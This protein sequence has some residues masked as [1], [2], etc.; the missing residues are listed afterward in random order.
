MTKVITDKYKIKELL[1]LGV[2]EIIVKKDLEKKLLSGK[3]LRIKH[4]VDPTSADLHLG[5]AVVY[6]KL[7]ELQ[8]LGHKIIFLIGGFTGRFGDPTDKEKARNLRTKEETLKLAKNY[9]KQLAKIL[10]IDK[11]EIRDNSEWYDKWSFE[12]GLKLISRFTVARMLERDM[13]VKRQEQGKE[14]YYHEPIYPM[15]QGWDSVELRSDLTVIG[16]DQKFNE[17]QARPLQQEQGQAP[18]D[19]ITVPLLIGTD[20]K[21][22]MSQSLGN[23]IGLDESANEQFGKIMSIPDKLLLHYFELVARYK[24]KDLERVKK[25]L[26]E[27]RNPK[28]LKIELAKKI[29]AIYHNLQLAD[30]AAQEFT[31]VFSNKQKPT[32]ISE[33]SLDKELDNLPEILVATKMLSSKSE[34]KRKIAEG[35]VKI[36]DKKV[37]DWQIKTKLKSG[38]ILQ[39]GK[40]KFIKIK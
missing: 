3:Q 32:E 4:G 29:V 15:L 18:Q 6:H 20:G 31:R 21:M 17:L 9:L 10:D 1:S 7:R 37:T 38:D 33:Y 25:E 36:N 19:I 26:T 2:E 39:V 5:Y 22:K 40:R 12:D 23:Y 13:F 35:A 30:K 14:I 24:K 28:E 8:E 34:A 16:T 27:G 11:V